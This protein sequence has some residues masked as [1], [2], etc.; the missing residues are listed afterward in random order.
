MNKYPNLFSSIKV[1]NYTYRNRI[2]TAPTMFAAAAFSDE[3]GENVRRMVERRAKGGAAEV[4]TGEMCVNTEEGDALVNVPVD[5]SRYEGIYFEGF[6]DYANRIKKNGAIAMI[7]LGHDTSYAEVKPPYSPYGPIAFVREDGVPVL[8]MDEAVMKKITDDFARATKFMMAAG[9]D[10]ILLH[11]GHGFLF[12]QFISPLF[13]KRT[14]KFGGSMENRARFPLM[15]LDAIREAGGE[16][17]ILELRFSAEDGL[18]GGMTINDCVEF[19][20]IIDGKVDIIHVSNGL[21]WMGYRSHTFTSMYDAHG[22][23]VSYAEKVKKAVIKSKVAVIGGIN[24]PDLAEEI[25]A[26]GKAD[27]VI[28]GRQAFAD[29]EFPNKAAN[30]QEDFIR[31]CVRCYHC[32]LGVYREHKT[33]LEAK[34][35]KKVIRCKMKTGQCAINPISNFK[36]YPERYPV[37]TC[38][39]KVLIVGGGVAGM[40]AAI[41]ASERG[42]KVTLVEKSGILGGILNFTDYDIYKV[43]LREFKN[44]LV[45][46]IRHKDI[47]VQLNTEVNVKFIEDFKPD[48]LILAVGSS[49]LVPKIPGIDY[50]IDALSV[51]RNMKRVGKK[52]ILIGGGLVGCE[53]GLHLAGSDRDVTIVEMLNRIAPET[54][55]MARAALLD[56]MDESGIHQVLGHKCV[57]ILPNGIKAVNS[58][59]DE[60]FLEADTVCYSAGMKSN[61]NTSANLKA[62][63]GSIPVFEIG[64]CLSVGKVADA[65]NTAYTTAMEI[66]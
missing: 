2:I 40:Q 19:C 54:Y 50:A 18:P 59:G 37:P 3:I 23:N 56:K 27:F 48:V 16:D 6:K 7:E 17:M 11:G 43:D 32:Y 28:L 29:P 53:V 13:N 62:A 22:Y 1:R 64:D 39:R 14:D 57:E 46:E 36:I 31:R 61:S 12:Q 49:P 21:K 15:V 25:I 51:Y 65:I 34:E 5:Y 41:T 55:T 35:L 8:A 42:H 10:G 66:V 30:G 44:V 45:R 60:I 9:F 33:D 58:Q 63:A 47:E 20:K 38:S 52:V 26:S 4:I 24:S